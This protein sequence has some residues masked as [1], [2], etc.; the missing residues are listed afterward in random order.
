MEIDDESWER[1]KRYIPEI[2]FPGMD[3]GTARMMVHNRIATAIMDQKSRHRKAIDAL[4]TAD[5]SADYTQGVIDSLE[6]ISDDKR[7]AV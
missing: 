2:F 7:R 5:D 6:A 1:A 4:I 3:M